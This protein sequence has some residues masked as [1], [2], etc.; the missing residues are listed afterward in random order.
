MFFYGRNI[1]Y[2]RVGA[3]LMAA[4]YKKVSLR[5]LFAFKPDKL[6]HWPLADV[7]VI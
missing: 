6:T 2:V 5:S 1:T 3:A 4:V 7:A